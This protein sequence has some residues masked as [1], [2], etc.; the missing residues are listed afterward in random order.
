MQGLAKAMLDHALCDLASAKGAPDWVHLLPMGFMKGRDG[1]SFDP[2]D[3]AGLILAF[4]ANGADLPVDYEHQ[5]DKPEA[6]LNGPVRAAGWIKELQARDDGLW[7]RVEWT[8]AAAEMIQAKEYR[9]LSPSILYHPKTREIMRVTGAG[10]VHRPNLHLTALNAQDP[11]MAPD[12]APD[13]APE[14]APEQTAFIAMVLDLL[15]LPANTPLSD[16]SA[17]LKANREAVPDPG[18]YMPIAAVQEMLADRRAER[19]VIDQGRAQE[20]VRAAIQQHY[21]TPGMREW[22]LGLCQSDEASFDAFLKNAGPVFSYLV[23]PSIKS[24]TAKR[25]HVPHGPAPTDLEAAL[26]EQLGL[27]PG[28]LSKQPTRFRV[29]STR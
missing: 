11:A 25:A 6:R 9:Y 7:G 22:A 17:M 27:P 29:G 13:I 20:K 24:E 21:I 28:S 12:T 26:C 5:N 18:K 23:G 14:I 15:G 2:G 8:A 19:R 3:P 16:A 1:R 4:Q 10:L